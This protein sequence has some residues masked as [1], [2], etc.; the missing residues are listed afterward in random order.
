MTY[1]LVTKF[2]DGTRRTTLYREDAH[3]LG[4]MIQR[5]EGDCTASAVK[6][7]K[8]KKL[9]GQSDPIA[10]LSDEDQAKLLLGLRDLMR[11]IREEGGGPRVRAQYDKCSSIIGGL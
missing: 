11:A 3:A 2:R 10:S 1:H 5:I 9:K 8:V 6:S 7:F 4:D